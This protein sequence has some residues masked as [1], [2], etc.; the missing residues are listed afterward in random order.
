MDFTYS[1]TINSRPSCFGTI[2]LPQK[3]NRVI[4][5][6]FRPDE[7][8]NKNFQHPAITDI[9]HYETTDEFRNDCATIVNYTNRTI[10]GSDLASSFNN[11]LKQ[12]VADHISRYRRIFINDL[13]AYMDAYSELLQAIGIDKKTLS[14]QYPIILYI[15]VQTYSNYVL[16]AF[17]SFDGRNIQFLSSPRYSNLKNYVATKCPQLVR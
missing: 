14:D 17:N 8:L 10:A 15:M 6:Q 7:I 4:F 16:E 2:R 9:T 5:G 11:A 3:N 12:I 13:M 1:F